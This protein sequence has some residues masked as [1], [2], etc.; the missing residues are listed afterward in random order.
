MHDDAQVQRARCRME[1][2][3]VSVD[4]GKRRSEGRGSGKKIEAMEALDH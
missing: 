4:E 3:G 1:E 2:G